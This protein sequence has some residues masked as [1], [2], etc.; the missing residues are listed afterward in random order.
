MAETFAGLARLLLAEEDLTEILRKIVAAGVSAIDACDH[1]GIDL[2]ENRRVTPVAPSDEF[3]ATVARIQ[4]ETGEGPCLSAIE[5]HEVFYLEDLVRDERWPAFAA[6]CR[7]ETDISSVLGFRLYADEDTMGA[8][9]LY[10]QRPHAFDA[11]AIAIGSVLAAHAAVAMAT[12]RRRLYLMDAIENRDI[13]GQAK[14]VL[15]ER[16]DL[17]A[18]EAFA[19]IRQASQ[20]TNVK[21]RVVAEQIAS[22][23]AAGPERA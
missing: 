2:V 15:M 8:L 19:L 6:R 12:E 16:E 14:G 7:A 21:V 18:D 22:R 5:E 11:E 13:I 4:D 20:R 1:A 9:N 10:A 17:D 3:A 23:G